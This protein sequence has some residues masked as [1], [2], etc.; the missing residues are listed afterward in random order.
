MKKLI[1]IIA[2][3]FSGMLM[4]AQDNFRWDVV[5]NKSGT[6]EEL[7]SKAKVVIAD[8]YNSATDVTKNSDKDLGII[9]IKAKTSLTFKRNMGFAVITYYYDYSLKLLFKDGKYRMQLNGVSAAGTNDYRWTYPQVSFTYQ[10]MGKTGVSKKQH[11]EQMEALQNRLDSIISRIIE[12]MNKEQTIN[13][14]W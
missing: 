7:Y 14:D 8:V 1:L 4:R 11:K 3:I 12:K 13:T 2:I 10:G 5:I 9:Q 6:K